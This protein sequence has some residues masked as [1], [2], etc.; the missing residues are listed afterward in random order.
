[1]LFRDLRK[2]SIGKI[3][4]KISGKKEREENLAH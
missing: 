2:K 3:K 1:M 4:E